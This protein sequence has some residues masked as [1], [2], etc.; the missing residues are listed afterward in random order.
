MVTLLSYP[1]L[2]IAPFA[3]PFMGI[4]SLETQVFLT[5]IL[6][7]SLLLSHFANLCNNYQQESLKTITTYCMIAVRGVSDLYS[8]S[9]AS[10]REDALLLLDWASLKANTIKENNYD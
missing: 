8:Q 9:E 5:L 10:A 7:S 3:L 4:L 1:A 6:V 2:L